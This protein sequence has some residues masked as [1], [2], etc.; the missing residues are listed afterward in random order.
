MF[1]YVCKEQR[2]TL[3]MREKRETCNLQMLLPIQSAF[4]CRIIFKFRGLLKLHCQEFLRLP[5]N[6]WPSPRKRHSLII[7]STADR[8]C[9]P[10]KLSKQDFQQLSILN[11]IQNSFLPFKIGFVG[12]CST[13]TWESHKF[14]G[15]IYP[16]APV[17]LF[18]R[19]SRFKVI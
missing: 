9:M 6:S 4:S 8:S 13:N 17:Y 14:G 1:L 5:M 7:L 18:S 11:I 10:S 15:K 12:N 2:S 16:D 3:Q 19:N